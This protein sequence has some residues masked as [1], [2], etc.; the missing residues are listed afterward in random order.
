M[1]FFC[2]RAYHI[3]HQALG[4]GIALSG[5]LQMRSNAV[6]GALSRTGLWMAL[7]TE[8]IISFLVGSQKPQSRTRSHGQAS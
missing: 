8:S 7:T 6:V 1:L 2:N 3:L 4:D 5:S